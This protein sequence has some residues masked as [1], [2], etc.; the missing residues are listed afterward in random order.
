M[1]C[2]SAIVVSSGLPITLPRNPL[3]WRRVRS[4]GTP[5]GVHEDHHAERFGAGPEGIEPGRR[6]FLAVDRGANPGAAHLPGLEGLLQLIRCQLGMLQGHAGERDEPIG[7]CGAGLGE[8]GILS[9]YEARGELA[10]G[11]IPIR[12]DR[13]HLGVDALLVHR[14][15]PGVVDHQVGGRALTAHRGLERRALDDIG[16]R[17]GYGGM[18]VH[19]DRLHARSADAHLPPA[20]RGGLLSKRRRAA[21]SDECASRCHDTA[22]DEFSSCHIFTCRGAPPPRRTNA[23]ASPRIYLSSAQRGR[24]RSAIL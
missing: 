13:D 1:R 18:R 3:P 21:A 23:D 19:I 24:R 6:E 7:M 9:G 22:G 14:A 12:V 17:G 11:G 2:A 4:S 10:V 20:H 15:Q 16:Q 8:R 5:G